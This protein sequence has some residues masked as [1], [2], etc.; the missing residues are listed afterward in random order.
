MIIL[1]ALVY[2]LSSCPIYLLGDVGL[3]KLFRDC[4]G[5]GNV[6]IVDDFLSFCLG[7]L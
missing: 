3:L 4:S 7:V 1:V 5:Q 6:Q 2:T